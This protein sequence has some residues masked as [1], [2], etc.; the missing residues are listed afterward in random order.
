MFVSLRELNSQKNKRRNLCDERKMPSM[1]CKNPVGFHPTSPQVLLTECEKI[2]NSNLKPHCKHPNMAPFSHSLPENISNQCKQS[3][4]HRLGRN[5]IKNEATK[6]RRT[7]EPTSNFQVRRV[8]MPYTP[9]RNWGIS[10]Q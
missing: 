1:P 8:C 5:L 3:H 2:K 4:M 6:K 9:S 10:T 7:A